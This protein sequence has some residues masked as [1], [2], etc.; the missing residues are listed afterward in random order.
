[1]DRAAWRHIAVSC[2]V[3][4]DDEPLPEKSAGAF[5]VRH[6]FNC[7]VIPRVGPGSRVW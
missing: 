5:H 6:K 1:M 4:A 2:R 3:I 7:S